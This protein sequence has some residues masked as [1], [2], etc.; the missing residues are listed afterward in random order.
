MKG[1][2]MQF[3]NDPR[4]G[5]QI[6]VFINLKQKKMLIL[7]HK[8]GLSYYEHM[9]TE[10]FYGDRRHIYPETPM[11]EDWCLVVQHEELT[12]F[13]EQYQ[14]TDFSKVMVTRNPYERLVSFFANAF[15]DHAHKPTYT[16][17]AKAG[18]NGR[19]YSSVFR[20]VYGE[21]Y[22]AALEIVRSNRFQKGFDMFLD[23]FFV[24]PTPGAIDLA[25]GNQRYGDPHLAQ[26]SM[27]YRVNHLTNIQFID[28]Y[29]G[30]PFGEQSQH[31]MDFLELDEMID[32]P[33]NSSSASTR[34][35][36][37]KPESYFNSETFEVVNEFYR[38]DFEDL[39]YKMV[40][41]SPQQ[42]YKT[43]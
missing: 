39:G 33:V 4:T 22:D 7:H 26:Q 2:I 11:I 15:W 30:P 25:A 1:K 3:L 17:P 42:N 40:T 37:K 29:D 10:N 19:G 5:N 6:R 41:N 21:D 18:K 16:D 14:E 23:R 9:L 20:R 28:L 43:P 36:A 24:H 32:R 12:R 35:K 8:C 34:R 38:S 31:V 13:L 27:I